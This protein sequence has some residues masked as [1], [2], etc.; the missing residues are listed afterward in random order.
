MS[1]GLLSGLA[2]LVFLATA[3]AVCMHIKDDP[4]TL[5]VYA[6]GC[7]QGAL[8]VALILRFTAKYAVS[9]EASTSPAKAARPATASPAEDA[10][11][12]STPRTLL[13]SVSAISSQALVPASAPLSKVIAEEEYSLDEYET[14][15]KKARG[16]AAALPPPRKSSSKS[17][18]KTGQV[19]PKSPDSGVRRRRQSARTPKSVTRLVAEE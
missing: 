7:T 16:G 3:V 10:E 4:G 14:M 2:G 12:A 1:S 15:R 6:L 17:P 19:T 8:L 5:A 11:C 18:G 13:K 9:G